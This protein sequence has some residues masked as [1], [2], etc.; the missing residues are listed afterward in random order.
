VTKTQYYC[1]ATLDGYIADRDD[2]IEWLTGYEGSYDGPEAEGAPMGEGGSYE[3]FYA[4]V[5]ALVSGSVTYE[6]V[7][8]HMGGDSWPYEGKPWFVLSSRDLPVPGGEGIDVR[9]VSGDIEDMHGEMLEAAGGRNLWVVGGGNLASQ[10]ADAGLLDE[11]IVTVVPVVL[12]EGKPLFE[13]ALP[14]GPMQLTETHVYG[15]GM[16]GLTYEI[17]R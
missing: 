5:G 8:E 9:V 17:K 2:G 15:T 1:A 3:S 16:V 4:D 7:L 13:R 12:G 11:V 14:G 6:W 10:F